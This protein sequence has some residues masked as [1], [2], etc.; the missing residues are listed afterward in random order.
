MVRPLPLTLLGPILMVNEYSRWWHE[1]F[2]A[3]PDPAQ[4]EREVAFLNRMLPLPEFHRVLD[5]A[6]GFGRNARLLSAR[7]TESRG[8]SVTRGWPVGPG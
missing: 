3:A 2:G 4:T 7:G 6:C 5:V 1:T 8:R